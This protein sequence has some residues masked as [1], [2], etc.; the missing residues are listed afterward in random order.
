VQANQ[1][2]GRRWWLP[3]LLIV[4]VGAALYANALHGP[5]LLDDQRSIDEN[6]SVRQPGSI[7]A[8]LHPPGQS[9]MTG[10]PIANLSL[11]LNYAVGGLQ[12]EGYHAVNI[13]IHILAALALFGVLR[14]TFARM[15]Y[16]R[17]RPEVTGQVAATIRAGDGPRG[18]WLQP[19]GTGADA[20]A[21]ICALIWLVHP[22]NSEAVNYVTQRTET[23]MGLFFLLTLYAAIRALD[24]RAPRKWMALAGVMAYCAVGSKET[25]LTLPLILVLWD[26]A[27]AFPTLRDAWK[28]RWRL[29]GMV[30]AS[31]LLFALFAPDLPFFAENGFE[32]QVSR[33]TYLLNQGPA[34]AQY[35]KL[36]LWPGALVFDYGA[37]LPVSLGTMWPGLLLVAVLLAVTVIALVRWPAVGFWGA[38]FFITLAPASSIIPIPTEVAAERRMYLPLIALVVLAA[39]GVHRL[40]AKAGE[41]RAAPIGVAVVGVVLITLGALTIRRNI[42]YQSALTIW[43]TSL[44]RW[45]QPRAREHL[46]MALRDAGRIEESIAQL[47][48]AA[49]D[50]ANARLAFASA[51]LERGELAQ[52]IAHFRQYVRDNP[53]SRNILMAREEFA[54]ALM[55]AGDTA[56][57]VEQ[58][59]AVTKQ[60]P[61]YARGHVMLADAR[62]QA[63][64]VAGATLAY[65]RAVE[66]QPNNVLALA[67]L[68]LLRAQA[69]DVK[70]AMTLLRRAVTLEPRALPPRRQIVRLLLAQ[71]RYEE[72]ASEARVLAAMAPDDPEAHNLLGIALA[73]SGQFAPAQE[74]FETVVRL[75]PSNRDARANLA[76]LKA[77]APRAP[78]RE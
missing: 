9:P 70:E 19:V 78:A 13:G 10:R 69:G 65:R 51:L 67:N 42:E 62:L 17:P 30:A 58:L 7:G 75:D 16:F 49:P 74:Q 34:I 36:T 32:Q 71:G 27:F 53:N 6:E 2:A 72:T 14:R 35:L 57:A 55:R 43:Q 25:A 21:L 11:A 50:S 66:L 68:G 22:L 31:W 4:V 23:L 8:I 48:I 76:R 1:G 26:R 40:M 41:R 3:L 37:P 63:N 56:G 12:V 45:P 44:D 15:S 59:E 18:F 29:Y 77:L 20:L 60:V 28:Q 47:K 5:F 33:W 39:T 46:S 38:W 61:E 54:L 52:A 64:D 73:S 24:A